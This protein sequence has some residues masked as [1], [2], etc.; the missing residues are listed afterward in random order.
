MRN[1][2]V[3]LTI[4]A[5]LFSLAGCAHNNG[6]ADTTTSLPDPVDIYRA[7]AQEAAALKD[8]ALIVSGRETITAG[9]EVYSQETK[10]TILYQNY[11]TEEMVARQTES[12]SYGDYQVA[13]ASYFRDKNCYFSVS[14]G[15][16]KADMTAE[17]YCQMYVP[18]V[19][20][21]ADLYKTITSNKDGKT[22]VY[23]FSDALDVESWAAPEDATLINAYGTAVLDE[24]NKLVSSNYSTR[25]QQGGRVFTKTV[26]VSINPSKPEIFF[27]DTNTY[28]PLSAPDAP[29]FME[30]AVGYLMQVQC[31]TSSTTEKIVC[32]IF[33]DTRTQITT[34][35]MYADEEEYCAQLDITTALENPS[36]VDRT[37]SQSQRIRY[38][39]GRYT[40]TVD[41]ITTENTSVTQEQMQTYC[42]DYL[43]ST[44]LMTKY[45][46]SI[47][48]E[49]DERAYKITF[50][51]NEEMAKIMR[52]HACETL[53]G[54]ASVLDEL[55][56]SYKTDKMTG[57]ITI[58]AKTHVPLSSGIQ[59]AGTH[60]INGVS[61]RLLFETTQ[62]Y[63]IPSNTAY[64]TIN[65]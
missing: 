1:K 10:Q 55:A 9:G 43:L 25:Y 26:S 64:S 51:A 35:N 13:V 17:D 63:T 16:Y 11:G 7:A 49:Q 33:G 42:Q 3:W 46:S 45:I 65:P 50:T 24:N 34:L 29:I 12:R 6:D 5:M 21:D 15:N 52:Q 19:L 41:G 14:D 59:Y 31:A 48:V 58:D 39:N 8:L 56:N 4:L 37:T 28:I 57:Y 44:I 22:T 20:F 54:D 18:A 61:Y 60:Q 27:P 23:S 38:T 40:A 53:Y 2:F 47:Q 30:Q 62:L 36:R 32:D